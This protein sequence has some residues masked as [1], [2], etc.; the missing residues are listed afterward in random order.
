MNR[1]TS[2]PVAFLF[3]TL[4]SSS[5]VFA[6]NAGRGAGAP[7]RSPIGSATRLQQ[8]SRLTTHDQD[9]LHERRLDRLYSRDLKRE[10]DRDRIFGANLMSSAERTQY[11]AHLRS[12]A[13]E[14]ERVQYRM[15]HQHQMQQRAEARHEHLGAAPSEAQ[16]RAQ[17]R[18]RQQ[19]RE[20]IYGYSMM[21]PQEVAHYQAQ[22]GAART[23]QE[24]EH[25]RAEHRQ[26]MEARTR[27]QGESPP[28]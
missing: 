27:A 12:L 20:Q 3:A 8:Q 9:R 25:I 22:M 6:Q 14:Q 23:V 16:I 4:L 2:T 11:E 18:V 17:E 1:S 24:R 19:E 26:Q 5:T 28:K 15:E 10:Q 13:T 21:T 7:A